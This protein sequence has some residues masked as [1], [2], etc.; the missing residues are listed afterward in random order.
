VKRQ[1]PDPGVGVSVEELGVWADAHLSSLIWNEHEGGCFCVVC[2]GRVNSMSKGTM[3]QLIVI[4]RM[5]DRE[6]RKFG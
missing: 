1:V 2:H 5:V 6:A 3:H 4:H